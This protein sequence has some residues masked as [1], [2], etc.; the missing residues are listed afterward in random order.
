MA[1][2]IAPHGRERPGRIGSRA[3]REGAFPRTSSRATEAR[4][5][6]VGVVTSDGS[7]GE[8]RATAGT[9]YPSSKLKGSTGGGRRASNP[10]GISTKSQEAPYLLGKSAVCRGRNGSANAWQNAKRL[11]DGWQWAAN[12]I[13]PEAERGQRP[14]RSRCRRSQRALF[15]AVGPRVQPQAVPWISTSPYT[16]A[17]AR[18]HVPGRSGRTSGTVRADAVCSRTIAWCATQPPRQA[19]STAG[20]P[21]SNWH[22]SW[23]STCVT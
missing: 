22:A 2:G 5:G 19:R 11:A 16:A 9:V 1:A 18:C 3:E 13:R 7:R 4:G 17:L 15:R 8:F 21:S 23:M 20:R 10:F 6:G 12:A 14:S